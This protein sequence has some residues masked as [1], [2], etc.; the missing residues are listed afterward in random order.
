PEGRAIVRAGAPLFGCETGTE[1]IGTI[2]SGG[3]GPSL[4]A[5]IAMGYV[6]AN[7]AEP[8]TR[9][10]TELRGRRIGLTVGPL[11]FTP[12]RYKRS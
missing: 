2:T 10:F 12:A 5:P 9:L 4:E 6:R 7:L 8:G 1:R 11:P 3:F